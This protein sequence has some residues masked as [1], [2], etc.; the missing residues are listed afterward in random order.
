MNGCVAAERRA[1]EVLTGSKGAI[2][3]SRND[4]GRLLK[5]K[6][7]ADRYLGVGAKPKETLT[8]QNNRI[9]ARSRDLLVR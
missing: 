9:S 4:P 1:A 5:S 3:S 7:V 8:R 6:D 2:L